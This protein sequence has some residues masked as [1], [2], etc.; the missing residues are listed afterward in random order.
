MGNVTKLRG[1]GKI[2]NWLATRFRF[3]PSPWRASHKEKHQ[4]V[5]QFSMP[6]IELD[7]TRFRFFVQGESYSYQRRRD[8]RGWYQTPGGGGGRVGPP[9]ERPAGRNARRKP[10]K[11]A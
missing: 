6:W 9:G 3:D 2:K 5:P 7:G 1:A 8:R 4:S 10:L 11:T